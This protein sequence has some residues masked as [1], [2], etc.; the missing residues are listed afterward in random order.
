[1]AAR[2]VAALLDCG[3]W[4][5]VVAPE[6]S[7]ELGSLLDNREL[8]DPAGARLEVELRPYR[9]G[10][11]AGYR[12]VIAATG[13]RE[14]DAS[15]FEDAEEA[16][17][18][19]NCADDPDHC[20]A[21]LPAVHRDGPVVLSVATSG[22]SPALARWLRDRLAAALPEGIGEMATLVDESRSKIRAAAGDTGSVAWR[23]LFDGELPSLVAAHHREAA[24]RLLASAAGSA[25]LDGPHGGLQ[26]AQLPDP[27]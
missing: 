12:L 8:A 21:L 25:P 15:V 17:V 27:L 13:D 1:M 4:V 5:T 18:W 3:A 6:L 11:A 16:G 2:K 23:E 24:R 22:T 20:S 9:R 10:E 14:V 26:D 19:V 7:A